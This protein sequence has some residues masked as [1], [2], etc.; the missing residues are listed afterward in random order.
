MFLE[1]ENVVVSVVFD[2]I[3]K[4]SDLMEMVDA[5]FDMYP[6][7][8]GGIQGEG[9]MDIL[10]QAASRIEGDRRAGVE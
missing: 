8:E 3:I 7:R 6:I 1:D 10:A 2:W 9:Y 4:D 5:E